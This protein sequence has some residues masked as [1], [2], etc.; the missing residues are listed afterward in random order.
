MIQNQSQQDQAIHQPFI[1]SLDV[2]TSSTRALLFDATGAAVHGVQSQHTYQLTITREGEVSVDPNMLL[3]TV[4][5]T[6]DE[7]LHLAGPLAA[8][9]GVVAMDTFWHGLMGVD[10]DNKAVTPRSSPGKI[11]ARVMR[12]RSCG[13]N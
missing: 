6:I 1:L 8:S 9:I 4:A 13:R 10:A 3:A 11:H 2:G 12:Q 7:V 5:Q